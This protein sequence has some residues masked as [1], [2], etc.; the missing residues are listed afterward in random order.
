MDFRNLPVKRRLGLAIA[1]QGALLLGVLML[2]GTY[3][4]GASCLMAAA[5]LTSAAL[6]W[7]MAHGMRAALARAVALARPAACADAALD[8][9]AASL[10][11]AIDRAGMRRTVDRSPHLPRD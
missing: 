8:D 11:R 6:I 4:S 5:A 7:W 3:R 2:D 1:G 10:R 9:A